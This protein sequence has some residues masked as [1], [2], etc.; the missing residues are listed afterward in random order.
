MQYKIEIEVPDEV[1]EKLIESRLEIGEDKISDLN[2][3]EEPEFQKKFVCDSLEALT[4]WAIL[5]IEEIK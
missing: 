4:G 2:E 3:F 1:F 5:S